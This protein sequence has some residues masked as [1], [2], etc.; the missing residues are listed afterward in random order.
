MGSPRSW[1]DGR[2]KSGESL[3]Y[4]VA[5]KGKLEEAKALEYIKQIGSALV[6]CHRSGIIH[7]DCHPNNILIRSDDDKAIL[8]DFGIAGN[9][10]NSSVNQAGNEAFAPW[11]QTLQGIK[12]PTIDVYTL[13][14]TLYYLVTRKVPIP[15]IERKLSPQDDLKAPKKY[16]LDLSDRV[17]TAILKGME[18]EPQNRPQTMKEWLNLLTTSPIEPITSPTQI[19]ERYSQ[20]VLNPVSQ[21]QPKQKT[22]NKNASVFLKTFEFEVVTIDDIQTSSGFMGLGKPRTEVILNRRQSNAK[23]FSEDLGNGITLDMVAIS[24]GTFMMGTEEAE[25]ERLNKKYYADW[26]SRESPQHRVTVP[27]FY[28]GKFQVTQE[29]WQ[30]VA[31][32]PQIVRKLK[33]DPSRFK[34]DKLPVEQVSWQDAVEFCAR[35]SKATGKEYRLPSEAK[36]EYAC[37]AGTTTPFHFGETITTDLANYNGN[38]TYAN[39]AKGKYRKQTTEVGSFPPNAF[40][41]YDMHGNVWEWC[42]D[43]Y[44]KNYQGAP[45]DGS[46]WTDK[47]SSANVL[48]GG[49]WSDNPYYCRSA[50]R[51]WDAR[52]IGSGIGFRCVVFRTP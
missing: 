43:N 31:K 30:R 33:E 7:R 6:L 41:L 42:A 50:Y 39:E 4:L 38:H 20:E 1:S 45:N 21:P 3:L 37:R 22:Q 25:I 26:F 15:C 48:R 27:D 46:A 28:M 17:N 40:G 13:A 18:I 52:V 2:F 14:A 49:S 11:E 8:I 35:L 24:G 16:N 23:Y 5:N 44:H 12:A 29:Q 32:L 36:W 51:V 10:V 9:V 47:I 19:L 34:G